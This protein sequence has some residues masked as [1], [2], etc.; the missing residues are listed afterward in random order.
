M[1]VTNIAETSASL[2]G[3]EPGTVYSVSDGETTIEFTTL[4]LPDPDPIPTRPIVQYLDSTNPD[5]IREDQVNIVTFTATGFNTL[6]YRRYDLPGFSNVG[7]WAEIPYTHVADDT[8]QFFAPAYS[9]YDIR[10]RWNDND[11]SQSQ[12][13]HSPIQGGGDNPGPFAVVPYS[14]RV[15][16]GLSIVDHTITSSEGIITI[17]LELQQQLQSDEVPAW[18]YAKMQMARPS[19]ENPELPGE[20]ADVDNPTVYIGAHGV[21]SQIYPV[22]T[23]YFSPIDES[24]PLVWFRFRYGDEVYIPAQ[25]QLTNE[26]V[27]DMRPQPLRSGVDFLETSPGEAE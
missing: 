8:Y 25:E 19:Q 12:L 4:A 13:L 14:S 9:G 24:G 6:E 5:R 26:Y 2:E 18:R 10:T 21:F 3:L 17:T 7:E 15:P 20:F 16:A 27:V 23:Q 1:N 11:P 22:K